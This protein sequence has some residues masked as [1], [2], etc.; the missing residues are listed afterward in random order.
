MIPQT[1]LAAS[2]ALALL[3][4]APASAPGQAAPGDAAAVEFFEK[5]VRP[6]L[7]DNCYN[8]HSA[9]TNASPP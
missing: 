1:R 7:V 6:L 9:N 3:A 2:L 4:A 8:C 5:E